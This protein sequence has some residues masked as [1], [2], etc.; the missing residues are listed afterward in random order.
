MNE[1][2]LK[3]LNEFGLT[4]SQLAEKLGVQRSNVSHVLSGRNKPGYEFISTLIKE[5]P[6]INP[7]WVINGDGPMYNSQK[8][9]IKGEKQDK[10]NITNLFNQ[11]NDQDNDNDTDDSSGQE[12][13]SSVSGFHSKDTADKHHSMPVSPKNSLKDTKVIDKIV[14]FYQ[15]GTFEVYKS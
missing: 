2:L 15:D 5:F 3:I 1:R 12:K 14:F 10:N 9:K 4:S 13:K 6:T 7:Y 11:A 8:D